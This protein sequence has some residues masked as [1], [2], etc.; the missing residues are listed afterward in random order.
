M[1]ATAEFLEVSK[2]A[3]AKS[4]SESLNTA[5]FWVKNVSS[6]RAVRGV[7]VWRSING[8]Y[9]SLDSLLLFFYTKV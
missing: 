7:F 3:T 5:D 4:G 2:G 8:L 9:L 1:I 6:Y